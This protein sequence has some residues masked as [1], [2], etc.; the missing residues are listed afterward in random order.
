MDFLCT[1]N[2]FLPVY[3]ENPCFRGET[4]HI[5]YAIKLVVGYIHRMRG[6]KITEAQTLKLPFS[7]PPFLTSSVSKTT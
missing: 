1:P 6:L 5:V 7:F 4:I 3:R 2:L